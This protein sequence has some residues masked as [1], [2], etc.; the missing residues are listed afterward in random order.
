MW[1]RRLYTRPGAGDLVAMESRQRNFVPGQR[2]FVNARDH[3]CR[4][5]YC[6]APIRHTDHVVPAD[7]HGPTSVVNAQGKCEACNYAKEA[8]GWFD[9]VL[10]GDDGPHEIETTTPTGHRYRSRA[11]DPP[12]R[13]PDAA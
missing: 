3:W 2:Q 6:E 10:S 9:T 5:P 12:G 7:A 8:P 13:R 4:T 1:I 11:P